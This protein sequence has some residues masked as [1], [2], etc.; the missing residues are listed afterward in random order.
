MNACARVS[1]PLLPDPNDDMVVEVA[2]ASRADFI[3]THNTRD[4]VP[5]KRLGMTTV[6]VDN[7]S[8]QASH[9]AD[10]AFIDYRITDIGD[11]LGEITGGTAA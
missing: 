5:A 1:R 11:W 10:P 6:W 2:I 9:D 7:G 3:V 8:E 4:F